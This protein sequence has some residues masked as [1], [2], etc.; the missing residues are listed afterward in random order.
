MA[1]YIE[2]KVLNDFFNREIRLYEPCPD[3]YDAAVELKGAS[4]SIPAADVRPVA[5]GHWYMI[6]YDEAGCSCCGYDRSTPFESTREAKEKWDE[7][8]PFCEMC[9]ADMRGESG[10]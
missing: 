10:V 2:R 9:G 3:K 4:L 1:E 7:L 5:R 8:P 6:S